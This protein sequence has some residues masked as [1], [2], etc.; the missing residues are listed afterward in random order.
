MAPPYSRPATA[1]SPRPP[2]LLLALGALAAAFVGFGRLLPGY[3][4]G[5][6]FAF[7]GRYATFPF[8]DWPALFVRNWQTGLFSVDLREIRPLNALAFMLDARAWG[9]EPCG[10]RLTNTLLHAGCIA[11]VGALAWEVSRA[12][13]AAILAALL[14]AF[15]PA[16]VPAVGWITGRVDVLSTLFVLGAALAWLRYRAAHSP[17]APLAALALCFAGGLFTKESVLVFPA[18]AGLLDL[19]LGGDAARWRRAAW[20]RPY[21]VLGGVL[22]LYLGCRWAAFGAAGPAGIGRGPA[23]FAGTSAIW[24][25]LPR[26]ARYLA[27]LFPPTADWL[28]AWRDRGFPLRDDTFFRVSTLALASAA[29]L[30]GGARWIVRDATAVARRRVLGFGV[31]WYLVTTLPLI[32]TYFSP[33]HLYL[34]SAGLAVAL[35]L[36]AHELLRARGRFAA[37]TATALVCLAALQQIALAPWRAA[38]ERSRD[39]SSAVQAAARDS[40]PGAFL[41]IDAPELVDGAFCWSWAVPHCL[42]PPFTPAPLDAHVVPLARPAT[43]AFREDWRAHL[44]LAALTETRVPARLV[45]VSADRTVSVRVVSAAGLRSAVDALASRRESDDAA[46]RT[47]VRDLSAQEPAR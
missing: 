26:Q 37:M 20:W 6:D 36:A 15:H 44:P 24:E 46:W 16:T 13:R 8:S 35:A 45:R 4:V 43:T 12:R 3:F 11:L 40:A 23:T 17:R 30:A 31:G 21:L 2:R 42:R 32:V 41:L 22:A 39:L 1:A 9:A 33:R 25:T 5:D 19:S 47:L 7:I 38:A 18:L 14:F 29:A 34:T 10:F 27:H 28:A